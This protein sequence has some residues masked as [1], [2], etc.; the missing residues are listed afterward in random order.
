M[1]PITYVVRVFVLLGSLAGFFSGWALLAHAPKPASV[2]PSVSS[3]APALLPPPSFDVPSRMQ[4]LSPL[5]PMSQMARP[6]LRTRG[7]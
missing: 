4:P 6:R 3:A 2:E 5:P 7:S 1:K